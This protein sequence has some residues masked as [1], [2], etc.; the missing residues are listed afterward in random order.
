MLKSP[1]RLSW[2]YSNSINDIPMNY[3]NDKT[4]EQL[5]LVAIFHAKEGL[6]EKL[7]KA[8]LDL[9]GKTR[10]EEGC[11]SYHLYEDREDP[12]QFIFH[13]IWANE[14]RLKKHRESEHLR[15][16]HALKDKLTDRATVI[17]RWERSE[18]PAPVIEKDSLVLFAYNSNKGQTTREWQ[19]ILE[20][21][22]APTLAEKG[23]LHYELHLSKENPNDFMF[24][25]TWRTVEDWNNHMAAPHLQSLLEIIDK[26]TVNGITVI[27]AKPVN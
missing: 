22:I 3:F 24:H 13:E 5:T 1:K 16:F 17:Q 23:A 18:A 26:H 6:T 14:E 8:C 4:A 15:Q 2:Q 25:E 19:K 12:R 20:D 27:K 11:I 7:K 10:A 9:I 21:L